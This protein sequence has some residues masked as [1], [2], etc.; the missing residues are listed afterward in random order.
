MDSHSRESLER[1]QAAGE[2]Q[3]FEPQTHLSTVRCV[4]RRRGARPTCGLGGRPGA[5]RPTLLQPPG[6]SHAPSRRRELPPNKCLGKLT[7]AP[8]REKDG[9]VYLRAICTG[10]FVAPE[11]AHTHPAS[12][13]VS[14]S[15]RVFFT[16]MLWDLGCRYPLA[17]GGQQAR[18]ED[19]PRGACWMP[20]FPPPPRRCPRGH[21]ALGVRSGGQVLPTQVRT[22]TGCHPSAIYS[23]DD[24][25]HLPC[26]RRWRGQEGD[27]PGLFALPAGFY[28]NAIFSMRPSPWPLT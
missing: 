23:T 17:R 19:A 12:L 14:G 21:L 27:L 7:A 2:T 18:L 25:E 24:A 5:R 6:A 9:A 13:H 3:P 20:E 26:A 4:N 8:R 10:S 1:T 28:S 16:R 15:R 22:D 11:A